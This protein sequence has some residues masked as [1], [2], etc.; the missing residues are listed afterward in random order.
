MALPLGCWVSALDAAVLVAAGL[1]AAGASKTRSTACTASIGA[2]AA[3]RA[4]ALPP[5][6][7]AL[8]G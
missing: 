5:A 7:I 4:A 2:R 8:F 3:E 6:R 1:E